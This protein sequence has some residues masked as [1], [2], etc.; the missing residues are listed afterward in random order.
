MSKSPIEN[1]IG[2]WR[3]HVLR[4]CVHVAAL[5][6]PLIYYPYGSDMAAFF[7]LSFRGF[8]WV[9]I[10][11][12][13]LFEVLRFTFGWTFWGHRQRE[14]KL[15]SSFAWSVLSICFVLMWAG[16]QYGIPIIASAALVDPL[17]GE[18]RQTL[19][20]RKFVTT[21]IGVVVVMVI[22]WMAAVCFG[23][24]WR[25]ALLMGPLT[26]ML[27]WPNFRWIDDNALMQ[28][29]PLLFILLLYGVA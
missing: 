19:L 13:I 12:N 28:L 9:I 20:E 10:G 27:E 17:L 5:I 23:I 24:D 26:V 4:R 11:F 21:L 3:G 22:W 7:H 15:I 14:K 2:G 1:T 16:K 18:L 29:V 25:L 6:I 8:L